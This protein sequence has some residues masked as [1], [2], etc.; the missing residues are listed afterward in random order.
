MS[1]STDN[2]NANAGV[3]DSFQPSPDS[4][5]EGGGDSAV[6]T[7]TPGRASTEVHEPPSKDVARSL[8]SKEMIDPNNLPRQHICPL[9]QEPPFE[10]VH[11]DVPTIG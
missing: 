8:F 6:C 11:F 3:G 10:G 4:N 1:I 9:T 5:S 7:V 2:V